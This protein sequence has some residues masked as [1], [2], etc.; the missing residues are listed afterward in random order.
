MV[1]KSVLTSEEDGVGGLATG[2]QDHDDEEPAVAMTKSTTKIP[3]KSLQSFT[4]NKAAKILAQS[5]D[6]FLPDIA[7]EMKTMWNVVKDDRAYVLILFFVVLTLG[8]S[9]AS[10]GR[11]SP[12]M[13]KQQ[14][15]RLLLFWL[16]SVASALHL[17]TADVGTAAAYSP[18]YIPTA[19]FGGD[20]SQFP[21]DNLFAA[22]GDGIWDNG[23][24]CGR[25]YLVKCLSSSVPGACP[26]DHPTIQIRIVDQASSSVSPPAFP[27]TTLALSLAAFRAITNSSASA[28]KIINVEFE[29]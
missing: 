20:V 8:M 23:A 6:N 4:P 14:Q 5:N 24:S 7:V 25:Q 10:T 11:A 17:S 13:S 29:Q 2:G 19:C 28:I 3:E 15:R 18:P 21:P 1:A 12:A 22:A 26:E 16:L 27:G 9:P